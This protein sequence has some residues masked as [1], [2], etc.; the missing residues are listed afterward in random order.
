MEGSDI[1]SFWS[2]EFNG[3][4]IWMICWFKIDIWTTVLHSSHMI[5]FYGLVIARRKFVVTAQRQIDFW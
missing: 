2:I 5:L 4:M 3:Q 1:K